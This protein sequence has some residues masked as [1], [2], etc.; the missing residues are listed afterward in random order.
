MPQ[1]ASW[2]SQQTTEDRSLQQTLSSKGKLPKHIA[3]IMDGNGRWAEKQ[4]FSR[5]AGHKEGIESV[6]D[7]VK[8]SSQL[9][10]KFLT[11]YAF[12]IENWNRPMTEV[13][14]LMKLLELYLRQEIEELHKNNVRLTSIGKISSLP[15]TVQKLLNNA[16]QQTKDNTGLT[17]TLALSYGSRWDI[18]RA[19]QMI[20][21]DVR[22]GKLS[23]EDIS[24]ELFPKYLQTA[25]MPDP[26]LLIRTSGEVRLSNFLLWEM[27]Y[28]EMYILD[29]YWPE[30]RREDL[31]S[32]IENFLNRERRFGKTSLQINPSEAEKTKDSMLMRVVNAITSV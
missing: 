20:A 15:K 30:F 26:D 17:L 21:L 19:V 28:G 9:G 31:Y 24:E 16:Y 27:A 18:V 12:S 29:K 7:I 2:N 5:V 3:I 22:R 32:A 6:R 8:A 10:I 25:D 11:L 23:P 13:G 14:S 1:K 4:G